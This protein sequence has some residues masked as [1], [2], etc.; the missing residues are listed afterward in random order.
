MSEPLRPVVLTLT[1]WMEDRL[2]AI[3][4]ATTAAAFDEAF[5]AF[6]AKHAH[7]TVNGKQLSREHYKQHLRKEKNDELSA[8]VTIS[9]TVEVPANSAKPS[10]AG[11]VGVFFTAAITNHLIK[12]SNVNSSLNVM[13]VVSSGVFRNGTY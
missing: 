13:Y 10:N 12:T 4:S 2:K 6:L 3:Y 7:I 8:K 11:N 1:A 9:D 5:D